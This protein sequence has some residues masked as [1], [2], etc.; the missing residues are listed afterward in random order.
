MILK[1][2]KQQM[3]GSCLWLWLKGTKKLVY[4]MDVN[5]IGLKMLYIIAMVIGH[6]KGKY[7]M[8][9]VL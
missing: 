8:T 2:E 3:S 5:H 1:K 4:F 7:N 9:A 6:A